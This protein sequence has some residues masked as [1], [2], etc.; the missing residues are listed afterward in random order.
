MCKQQTPSIKKQLRNLAE[1]LLL[2]NRT[3]MTRAKT[4]RS[5]SDNAL[6]TV[7][8]DFIQLIVTLQFTALL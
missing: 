4:E 6:V 7:V 3:Q 2:E 1:R 5:Q 8:Q